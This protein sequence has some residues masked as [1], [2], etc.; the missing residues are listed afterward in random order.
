M[1]DERQ[2]LL[3]SAPLVRASSALLYNLPLL[4]MLNAATAVA[5]SG[6]TDAKKVAAAKARKA[7][8]QT[9]LLCI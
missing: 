1:I 3:K 6:V 7:L 2:R 4:M 9:R 5:L 8:Q